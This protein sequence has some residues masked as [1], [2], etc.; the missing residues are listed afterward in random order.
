MPAPQPSVPLAAPAGRDVNR[1]VALPWRGAAPALL[2]H[3]RWLIVAAHLPLLGFAYALAYALRFDFALPPDEL[4]RFWVTLPLLLAVR[5]GA[6]AW[7]GLFQG[8]WR[9]AGLPALIRI[10]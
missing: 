7:Y 3:R 2:R 9:H 10:A 8:M 4:R 6:F 1:T 5:L